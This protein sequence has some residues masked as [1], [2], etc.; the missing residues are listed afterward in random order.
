MLYDVVCSRI[1]SFPG[2]QFVKPFVAD[3][4]TVKDMG[5]EE[6]ARLSVEFIQA[7]VEKKKKENKRTIDEARPPPV[8]RAG[9]DRAA[10]DEYYKN[11]LYNVQKALVA[12]VAEVK[13]QKQAAARAR[14]RREANKKNK[15]ARTGDAIAK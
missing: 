14:E 11:G 12:D 9:F 1:P 4:E 15:L 6:D 5:I 3:A 8:R 7:Q 10:K 13:K 2:E